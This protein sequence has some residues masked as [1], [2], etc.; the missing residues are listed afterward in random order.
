MKRR[1]RTALVGIIAMSTLAL[2]GCLDA[3]GGTAPDYSPIA[4]AVIVC[5]FFNLSC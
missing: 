1:T 4:I 3:P 2:P 5:A